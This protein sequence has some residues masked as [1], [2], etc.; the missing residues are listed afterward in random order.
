MAQG[1]RAIIHEAPE[2]AEA[3]RAQV[4]AVQELYK[5]P[6]DFVYR[7]LVDL[8]KLCVADILAD[9]CAFMMDPTKRVVMVQAQ[10]GQAK[11]TV[12]AIGI[13]WDLV[14]NPNHRNAVVMSNE[15]KAKEIIVMAR[16]IFHDLP[17]LEPWLPD[18]RGGDR[19][20]IQAWD[21]HHSLRN[22]S[23]KSP[24]L[25]PISLGE[26]LQG[27]RTDLTVLDD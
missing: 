24:S 18:P 12:A 19:T 23:E 25:C 5:D 17:E 2:A 7:V 3:R 9:I 27:K 4:R 26:S 13:V 15:K 8:K 14:M 20:G 16:R 21:V 22:M 10:R 6:M 1:R 11:S